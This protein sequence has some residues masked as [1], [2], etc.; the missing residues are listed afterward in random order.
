VD[1]GWKAGIAH[2]GQPHLYSIPNNKSKR[3]SAR[4][5]VILPFELIMRLPPIS[6][7]LFVRP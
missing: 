7:N 6:K 5:L 4:F 3:V 2:M 1:G